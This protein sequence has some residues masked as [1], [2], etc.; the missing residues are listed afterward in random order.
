MSSKLIE[1]HEL[2][3][4][5]T[6]SLT[7]RDRKKG[8]YIQEGIY[9]FNPTIPKFQISTLAMQKFCRKST[10]LQ[11]YENIVLPLHCLL[12]FLCMCASTSVTAFIRSSIT[13]CFDFSPAFL[14]S[15]SLS[16]ISFSA[17]FSAFSFDPV[18]Y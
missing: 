13:C 5:Q 8:I 11:S 14:I 16:S 9:R 7:I 12:T 2:Q 15:F 10:K 4:K 1:V 6:G 3:L 18:C 17:S